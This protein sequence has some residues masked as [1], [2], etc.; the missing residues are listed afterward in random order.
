[1]KK[2]FI[3]YKESLQMKKLGF[4]EPCF[5]WYR[6]REVIKGSGALNFDTDGGMLNCLLQGDGVCAAPLYQQA[7]RWFYT[8]HK[9]WSLI[10]IGYG[11]E[12]WFDFIIQN[13]DMTFEPAESWSTPNK[14]R[15][16]CLRKLIKIV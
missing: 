11:Y 2:E 5:A 16:A 6:T 12:P 1:M 14:A 3:P 9:L 4:D 8:Q 13:S 10:R 7:F 15:L